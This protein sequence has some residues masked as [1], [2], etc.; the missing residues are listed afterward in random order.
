M[1]RLVCS[2]SLILTTTIMPFEL[3]EARS[4]KRLDAIDEKTGAIRTSVRQS[5]TVGLVRTLSLSLVR[6]LTE[7]PRLL[8]HCGRLIVLCASL[9]LHHVRM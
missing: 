3:P 1:T 5:V 2:A 6:I 9:S 8:S 4:Y 7:D